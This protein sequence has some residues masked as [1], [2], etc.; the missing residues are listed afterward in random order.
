MKY[1]GTIGIA[2]CLAVANW[3]PIGPEGGYIIVITCNPADPQKMFCI[4]SGESELPVFRSTDHGST[5]NRIGTF[6]ANWCQALCVIPSADSILLALMGAESVLRS[7]D[8]G[9]SWHSVALPNLYPNALAADPFIAGRVYV[10]AYS[11]QVNSQP[12]V[13]VSTDYGLSWTA[14]PAAD[15]GILYSLD[16]SSTSPGVLYYGGDRGTVRR[17]TDYGASWHSRS[18][19]LRPD[20][21][22]L[23]LSV[24]HSSSDI[25]LA[26]T[27]HGLFRTTNAGNLW[28]QVG[29]AQFATCVDFSPAVPAQ[30]VAAGY[31]TATAIWYTT[32][33]G[34]SWQRM[35]QNP[36]TTGRGSGVFCDPATANAVWAATQAGVL[37]TTDLGNSWQPRNSGILI[38]SVPAL[39]SAPW[40]RRNVYA[41]LAGIGLFKSLDGGR[42]WEKTSD[43]LSCGN[44]CAIG[45]CPGSGND[46]LYALEGSG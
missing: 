35:R 36:A 32:D 25:L 5:W 42:H 44:I 21:Y 11:Y 26:G 38:A 39:N 15:S 23:S 17:S 30:A 8:Y 3:I 45:L 20:D 27:V 4:G 37:L 33:H 22:I 12:F 46:I 40:N 6:P 34:A 7:T 1:L 19:G 28:T 13:C 9:A 14:V 18:T 16:C 2:V 43:F 31:D 10:G 41:S 24:N 29:T